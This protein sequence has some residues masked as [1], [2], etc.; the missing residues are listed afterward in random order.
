MSPALWTLMLE[1]AQAGAPSGPEVVAG[2]EGNVRSGYTFASVT[3]PSFESKATVVARVSTSYLYYLY[4]GSASEVHVRSPGL[5]VGAG[6]RWRPE[7]VSFTAV[8]GY[9]ARYT[10]ELDGEGRMLAHTD[11]GAMLA[12]DVYFQSTTRLAL[13]VS[14]YYGF[15]QEYL[16]CRALAK[17]RIFPWEGSSVAA[18][19]LGLDGT[20]R[21][22]DTVRGLDVG[23]LVELA[24]PA[25]RMSFGVHI[26]MGRE[27]QAGAGAEPAP[28]LGVSFYKSF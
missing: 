2:F 9:E 27:V 16:W 14:G 10:M 8:A 3:S 20:V 28:S 17:H 25:H 22:N 1:A 24:I 4:P 5:A 11:H 7:R 26:G 19:S 21:G 12:T 15:A 18:L 6:V 13:A 23:A